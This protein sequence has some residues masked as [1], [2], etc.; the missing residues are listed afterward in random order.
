MCATTLTMCAESRHRRIAIV[1][2]SCYPTREFYTLTTTGPDLS[3]WLNVRAFVVPT[4]SHPP[5]ERPRRHMPPR[6]QAGETMFPGRVGAGEVRGS[7]WQGDDAPR[8]AARRS[9]PMVSGTAPP[10]HGSTRVGVAH[11]LP[12][13]MA[14]STVRYAGN[15]SSASTTASASPARHAP[16]SSRVRHGSSGTTTHAA[17][18][19]SVRNACDAT[20]AKADDADAPRKPD[21]A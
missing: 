12:E 18:A 10:M 14:L 21:R 19:I 17:S 20:R 4:I 11:P 13:G 1:A 3:H 15:G 5:G 2:L 8:K 16:L 9:S 6:Y 7:E